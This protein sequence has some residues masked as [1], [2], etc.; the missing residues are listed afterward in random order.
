MKA[1]KAHTSQVGGEG[2][3]KMKN[4]ISLTA[5]LILGGCNTDHSIGQVDHD[6]GPDSANLDAFTLVDS[7]ANPQ[8]HPDASAGGAVQTP[9]GSGVDSGS[10]GTPGPSQWWTGYVENY[11]F[12]SG[13]DAIRFAFAED[14]A[15]QITGQII[16]GVGTPS[17]P[18]TDPNV[19]YLVG[20]GYPTDLIEGFAY[21]M[22][23]GNL[24]GSRL[25]FGFQPLEPWAGWCAMQT[26]VDDSGSCLPNWASFASGDRTLCYLISPANGE[27][28]IVDCGKF[29]LCTEARVCACSAAGCVVDGPTPAPTSFD[30]VL[31]NSTAN[32]SMALDGDH[33]IHFTKD[34]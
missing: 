30:L 33:N 32:G 19:G 2:N 20:A 24:S 13:S 29:T 25:R 26:P 21:S 1:F 12:P 6:A 31:S 5:L 23:S 34:P 28:L 10:V 15:G 7:V 18:A 11:Q 9:P 27:N 4:T 3:R 14:S 16:L 8:V 17:P 22:A